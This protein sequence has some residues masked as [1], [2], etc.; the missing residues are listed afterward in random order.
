MEKNYI[1]NNKIESISESANS[2]KRDPQK[3][4]DLALACWKA[5]ADAI[6]FQIYF[7][8]QLVSFNH[9]RFKHFNDQSFSEIIW[10]KLL[11]V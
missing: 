8:Q 7:A 1:N 11:M 2:H 5:A 10:S 3:L 6:K 4:Y 9:K